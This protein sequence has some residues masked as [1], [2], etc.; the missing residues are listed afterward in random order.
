M[1]G[2]RPAYLADLAF[3]GNS[4]LGIKGFCLVSVPSFVFSFLR[5]LE[6]SNLE[7]VLKFEQILEAGYLNSDLNELF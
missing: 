1:A 3:M 4:F 7:A 2:C 5:W 6:I